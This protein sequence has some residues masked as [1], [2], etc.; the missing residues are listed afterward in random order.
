MASTASFVGDTNNTDEEQKANRIRN[1]EG[2]IKAS[3]A[4]PASVYRAF[5]AGADND[6][7]IKATLKTLADAMAN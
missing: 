2:Y 1:V 6:A 5:L 4:H 3:G 7:K